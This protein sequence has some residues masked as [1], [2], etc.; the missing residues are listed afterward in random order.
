M[1]QRYL[2]RTTKGVFGWGEERWEEKK[3]PTDVKEYI[4]KGK[5]KRQ[6]SYT[7]TG[8]MPNIGNRTPTVSPEK[9]VAWELTAWREKHEGNSSQTIIKMQGVAI[10]QA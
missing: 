7:K 9:K 10:R 6:G 2:S 8:T 1:K 4:R 3:T 5:K